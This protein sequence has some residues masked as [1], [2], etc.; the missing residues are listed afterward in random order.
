MWVALADEAAAVDEPL[1]EVDAAALEALE[2]LL[3]ADAEDEE[4]ALLVLEL[5]DVLRV[6]H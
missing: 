2:E 1:A 5:A 3:D 4:A 6:P